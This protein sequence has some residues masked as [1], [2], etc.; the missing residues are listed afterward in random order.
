MKKL[1]A[2]LLLT[3]SLGGCAFLQNA[4]SV[5]TGASVTPQQAYIAANAFD[6]VEASATQYLQLPACG[7]TASKLCRTSAGVTAVVKA[8]RIGRQARNSLEAAVTSSNGAP[9]SASLYA[10]LTAQTS[11]LQSIIS[12]YNIGQ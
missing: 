10:A 3:L 11:T 6:T 12:S 9:V 4:Y 1:A 5:A 2:I 8:I 7:A